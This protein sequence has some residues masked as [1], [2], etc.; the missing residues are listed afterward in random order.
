MVVG[1]SADPGIVFLS[2]YILFKMGEHVM[3][4]TQL[5]GGR[6]KPQTSKGKESLQNWEEWR[7]MGQ[8]E[9]LLCNKVREATFGCQVINLQ[10]VEKG[11]GG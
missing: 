6:L 5:K 7:S 9:N 2:D 3:E 8:E 11:L 1:G 4:R 10:Q